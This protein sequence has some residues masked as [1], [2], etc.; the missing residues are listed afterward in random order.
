MREN[1]EMSALVLARDVLQKQIDERVALWRQE[2]LLA[3]IKGKVDD[4]RC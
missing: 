4:W 2:M 1:S 3:N